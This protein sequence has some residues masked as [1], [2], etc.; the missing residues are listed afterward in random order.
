MKKKPNF[1][2]CHLHEFISSHTREKPFFVFFNEDPDCDK[3]SEGHSEYSSL[4]T[5]H[6]CE[7][8]PFVNFPRQKIRSNKLIRVLN[9][10]ENRLIMT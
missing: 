1:H 4:W 3:D 6:P 8:Y 9:V 5:K 2:T 7:D 10:K